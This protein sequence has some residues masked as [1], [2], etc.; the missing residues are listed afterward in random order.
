VKP[1][2]G[3]L[4]IVRTVMGLEVADFTK[5]YLDDVEFHEDVY[6]CASFVRAGREAN[7]ESDTLRKA[8]RIVM[9]EWANP[10]SLVDQMLAAA[11]ALDALAALRTTKEEGDG[12]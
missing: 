7:S 10:S 12:T 4:E 1:T 11:D 9:R 3:E 2:I 5:R 6:R 8:A